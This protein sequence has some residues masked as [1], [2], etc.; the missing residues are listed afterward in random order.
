MKYQQCYLEKG[1]VSQT[2]YIPQKFAKIGMF[3]KIKRHSEWENGWVVVR[4]HSVID[5]P[6]NPRKDVREHRDNTGDSL[7]K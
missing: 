6:P 4:K 2:A 3:L 1:N 7:L 5:R